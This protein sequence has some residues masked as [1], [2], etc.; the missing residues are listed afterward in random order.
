MSHRAGKR[1]FVNIDTDCLERSARQRRQE[2]ALGGPFGLDEA[3][4]PLKIGKRKVSRKVDWLSSKSKFARSQ[5]VIRMD[6][7]VFCHCL[8]SGG[9]EWR[10]SS[11]STPMTS[12]QGQSS[13]TTTRSRDALSI[14]MKSGTTTSTMTGTM[15]KKKTVLY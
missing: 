14:N 11:L 5:W 2:R 8:Q 10:I 12:F 7:D 4:V 9:D 3:S 15:D 6:C 13:S 1:F